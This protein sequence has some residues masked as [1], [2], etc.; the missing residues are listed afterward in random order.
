MARWLGAA[1][2]Y[3]LPARYEPFGLSVLEAALARCALVLGDIPSLREVWGD[4]ALYVPPD[5]AAALK[6]VLTRL[7]RHPGEREMLARRAHRRAARYQP[8]RMALAYQSVYRHLA[9]RA[10]LAGEVE[11]M[12]LEFVHPS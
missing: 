3:C 5:D 6:S 10:T 4:A 9:S 8:M 2:I 1:S 11:W 12:P 7:I